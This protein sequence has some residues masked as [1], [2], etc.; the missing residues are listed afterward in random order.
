MKVDSGSSSPTAPPSFFDNGL[1]V[2]TSG[3]LPVPSV[4]DRS[5]RPNSLLKGGIDVRSTDESMKTTVGF[6]S[7]IVHTDKVK[8]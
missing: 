3:V 1:G 2:R 4:H 5:V 8:G 6:Q 7:G